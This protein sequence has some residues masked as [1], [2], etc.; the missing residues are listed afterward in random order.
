[1]Q[2]PR[3]T[4][5]LMKKKLIIGFF[6]SVM[7]IQLAPGQTETYTVSLAPFSSDK[8]DEFSPVFYNN[9]IVFC[10][11]QSSGLFTD[12][13][14]SQGRGFFNIFFFDRS[15]KSDML[16]PRLFS[17]NLTTRLNDG[18][19]TFNASGD[20]VYY[21]RNIG[22]DQRIKDMS[23]PRNKL[24]IFSAQSEGNEWTKIRE[25]RLNNE[26]Y[27]I[28]MPCLSP[29]GMR[30]YFA[31][32][33]PGGSGGS[34]LYYCQLVNGYWTDPVNLGNII[35]TPGNES[36]PFINSSGELF[37]SSDGHPGLGGKD[38]F[39]SRFS[40]TAWLDPV[41]I[42]APVNSQYDDFGIISDALLSE[43]YF[44]S[45]RNES[46]DI[47]Y[48]KTNFPQIF[49]TGLQTENQY[50]FTFSDEGS[51]PVDTTNLRY[52]WNF[53][54]GKSSGMVKGTHCYPGPGNFTVKLDIVERK[55]GK[56][57][58]TKLSYIL[59]IRDIEQ[60]YISSPDI[61][62]PGESVEF[63][64]G[65]TFLPG[66]EILDY[67]WDFGDGKR[68]SGVTASHG[69]TEKGEYNINLGLTLKSE[70]NGTIHR[71]GVS[72]KF[73]VVEDLR[74]KTDFLA[75]KSAARIS[76]PDLKNYNN[77]LI[78]SRYSAE[79]EFQ[80][81]ALFAVEILESRSKVVLSSSVF[82]NIP[83]KY[84]IKE[85]YNPD[86]GIYSYTADRQM[87]L[88]ATYP[89]FVDMLSLGFENTRTIVVVLTDPPEKE[90]YNIV[91]GNGV[92]AETYFDSSD[93]L[94]SNAY[95]ILD[96]VVKLMNKYPSIKI[97]VAVHTDNTGSE[98]NA[99]T[100]TKNRS[101]NLVSYLINKGISAARLTA[102]GYGESK[103][104][105]PN[106]LRKDRILNQRVVFNII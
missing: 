102:K 78:K 39:F 6:I 30:L 37:F 40:D 32:D 81:D 65:K 87:S 52:R 25:F 36:Y 75:R 84:T 60:P 90:L 46:I 51:I 1:M 18:P 58:F 7:F 104:V 70:S 24:G 4:L 85:V 72:K 50:C 67:S 106:F 28:T 94:T 19:V 74:N 12:Y 56:L 53:G 8:Y 77:A 31:S 42:D 11:N 103:P 86:N 69:F 35:N 55:T 89:A 95:I 88:M 43:G 17:K 49:Y 83:D 99:L 2:A 62:V 59:E 15:G 9:G 48:F 45:N 38:I 23:G 96:Q 22:V 97:E 21:S 66:Y 16:K 101:Q 34:D 5:F 61:A 93:R 13:A 71:T 80:K 33:K 26:W 10:T 91:K 68:S 98:E 47:F 44:S 73:L 64:A 82:R 3:T 105:A 27:N 14:A 79:S 57:F 20:T 76:I 54:D 100:F 63:N 41:L 29:D 92:L